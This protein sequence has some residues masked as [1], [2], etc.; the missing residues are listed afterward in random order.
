MIMVKIWQ[1][2]HKNIEST[3][4][5]WRISIKYIFQQ[6]KA[7]ISLVIKRVSSSYLFLVCFL[8]DIICIEFNKSIGF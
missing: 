3:K 5:Y 8:F 1:L 7:L 2:L 4:I 6:F